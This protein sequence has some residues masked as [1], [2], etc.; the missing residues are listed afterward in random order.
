MCRPYLLVAG[1]RHYLASARRDSVNGPDT[2]AEVV[3]GRSS[4]R[5]QD[6]LLPLVADTVAVVGLSWRKLV[7]TKV[8]SILEERDPPWALVVLDFLWGTYPRCLAGIIGQVD[9]FAT[10]PEKCLAMCEYEGKGLV[11]YQ[12]RSRY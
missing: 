6:Q 1:A 5:S 12:G 11:V 2:V 3:V 9:S 10:N 4:F 8:L 7:G